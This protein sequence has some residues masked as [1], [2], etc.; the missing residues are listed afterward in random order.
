MTQ[1][2]DG[3]ICCLTRGMCSP[4]STGGHCKPQLL[5]TSDAHHLNAE[6]TLAVRSEYSSGLPSGRIRNLI[7]EDLSFQ[8]G[9]RQRRTAQEEE[10]P[11]GV[12]SIR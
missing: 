12:Q 3:V 9:D 4:R 2:A 5:R 7:Q 1:Y 11:R 10:A 6:D 8:E